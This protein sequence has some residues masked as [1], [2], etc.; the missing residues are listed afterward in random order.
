MIFLKKKTFAFFLF[1]TL[2][3][4]PF[5]VY[6]GG[7]LFKVEGQKIKLEN[8]SSFSVLLGDAEG[9][10]KMIIS[11]ETE[12]AKNDLLWVFPV[13]AS[14]EDVSHGI[15]PGEA[16]ASGKN[17]FLEAGERL[18]E[19]EEI[20][21]YSQIWPYFYAM[22]FDK[23]LEEHFIQ[24]LPREELTDLIQVHRYLGEKGMEVSVI[25]AKDSSF[26][27]EAIEERYP[28][29][30]LT[31]I[32][33]IDSYFQ[34]GS[35]L[36]VSFLKKPEKIEEENKVL[37]SIKRGIMVKFPSTDITYPLSSLEV[38]QEK[39]IPIVFSITGHIHPELFPEIKEEGRV[40]YYTEGEMRLEEEHK[41]FFG[42]ESSTEDFTKINLV[43][44]SSNFTEDLQIKKNTPFSVLTA[45]LF[46]KNHLF[47]FFLIFAFLSFL[48]GMITGPVVSQKDRNKKGFFRWGVIGFF[49]CFSIVGL[50]VRIFFEKMEQGVVQKPLFL[51]LYTFLFILF[52]YFFIGLFF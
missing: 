27:K 13:S 20:F 14:V 16:R 41:N 34:E 47:F 31:E 39:R 37:K 18:E 17:V 28:E 15:S 35:S 40:S 45:T 44:S 1:F 32:N 10:Q 30:D 19:L 52:S 43:T 49:N 38:Y 9:Y 6:G 51:F 21:Y 50:L 48:T 25:S 5:F 22:L 42:E 46:Q 2:L 8:P 11:V 24:P 7:S 4:F 36:V 3:V 23:E 29:K 12:N 33:K 26:L